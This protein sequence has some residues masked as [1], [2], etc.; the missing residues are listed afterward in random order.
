M[1]PIAGDFS[2]K[3]H[4]GRKQIDSI[5]NPISIKTCKRFMET[6]S[7]FKYDLY[8]GGSSYEPRKSYFEAVLKGIEHLGLRIYLASKEMNSYDEYLNNISQSRM[9]INTNYIVNSLTKK[10]MV[11][12]NIETFTCGSM[13]ITQNTSTLQKYFREGRDYVA[14]ESPADAIREIEKYHFDDSARSRIA[15]SGQLKTLQYAEEHYF[16]TKTDRELEI[17]S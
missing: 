4:K 10:H 16:V 15:L 8:M 1:I 2:I 14:A 13:L 7:L 12:R 9:V 6:D 3:S 5:F 17:C 11:G